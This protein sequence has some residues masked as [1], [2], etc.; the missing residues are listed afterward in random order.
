M[1]KSSYFENLKIWKIDF[2]EEKIIFFK[3]RQIWAMYVFMIVLVYNFE[4]DPIKSTI[5]ILAHK[6][7]LRNFSDFF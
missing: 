1:G 4:S 2:H 6:I 7:F 3:K 5:C